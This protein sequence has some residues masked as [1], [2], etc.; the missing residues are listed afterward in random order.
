MSNDLPRAR[1]PGVLS[2]AYGGGLWE[3]GGGCR[4]A[5][6]PVV[7]PTCDQYGAMALDAPVVRDRQGQRR[8]RFPTTQRRLTQASPRG[9]AL[10]ASGRYTGARAS[11]RSSATV[12]GHWLADLCHKVYDTRRTDDATA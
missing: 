11:C 3:R 10:S 5:T 12:Y 4:F 1:R 7:Q 2:R 9:L 6:T 8:C